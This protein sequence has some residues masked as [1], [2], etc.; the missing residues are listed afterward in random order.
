MIYLHAHVSQLKFQASDLPRYTPQAS[1]LEWTVSLSFW[2]TVYY[3][4]T[5]IVSNTSLSRLRK[6][7][8]DEST[9]LPQ[10]SGQ[11]VKA[12]CGLLTAMSLIINL[13]P[14]SSCNIDL[15]YCVL[16]YYDGLSGPDYKP[17]AR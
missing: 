10:R 2:E 6:Q 16:E 12:P 17:I 9:P 3:V 13:L 11:E 14:N 5:D 8:T 1:W 15:A 7:E 4:L